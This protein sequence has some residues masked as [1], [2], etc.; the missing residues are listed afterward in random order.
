MKIE[1]NYASF[2]LHGYFKVSAEYIVVPVL[3]TQ[4]EPFVLWKLMISQI[5]QYLLRVFPHCFFCFG[6][7]ELLFFCEPL[8]T[9]IKKISLLNHHSPVF[10]EMSS[11]FLPPYF[12]V[13]SFVHVLKKIKLKHQT[14]QHWQVA[15]L[16]N[17]GQRYS[18]VSLV[19]QWR[20][21]A[22]AHLHASLN[23]LPAPKWFRSA[24]WH[25][26]NPSSC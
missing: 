25:F 18:T 21:E 4:N 8:L 22:G 13:A 16:S 6:F 2:L 19:L 9:E 15:N 12:F 1:I 3:P 26:Y 20:G 23:L 5:C 10:S 24:L 17:L 11:Y 14:A 7:L